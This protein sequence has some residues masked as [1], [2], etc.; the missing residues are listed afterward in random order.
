M[1][2]KVLV[3]NDAGPSYFKPFRKLG[4]SYTSDTDE[5]KNNPDSIA[6]V[7]FTGGSDVS[8]D[9]YGATQHSSTCNNRSRD[10]GEM[11]IFNDA[12]KLGKP[13][14]GIC[15]G[16]QFLCAMAGG[17][18]VQDI[19]GHAGPRHH[20]KYYNRDGNIEV[21]PGTVTSSHHQMQN[22]FDLEDDQYE[23]IAWSSEPRSQHYAVGEEVL[24]PDEADG[25]FTLEPD[26]VYYPEIKALAAQYHPEWMGESEWGF[27]FFQE[28][29][30]DYLVPHIEEAGT[31]DKR[32]AR[33]S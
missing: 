24:S 6:L 32:G 9:I 31:Y 27:T 28:L 3:V 20:L 19:T 18:I 5:L 22:P 29:V 23:I 14:A 26:V 11:L 33:T 30:E 25:R 7:V 12:L 17:K 15:R 16:A 1:Q 4:L 13:F 2:K 8:P 10:I 21:S